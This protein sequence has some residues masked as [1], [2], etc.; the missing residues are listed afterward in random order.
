MGPCK[1][2]LQPPH[3]KYTDLLL[4]SVPQMDPDWLDNLLAKRSN[5]VIAINAAA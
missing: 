3:H 1:E 4:S 5:L 2:I